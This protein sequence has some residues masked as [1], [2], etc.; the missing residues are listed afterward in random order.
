MN[1]RLIW[2]AC[3]IALTGCSLT[4][5][6]NK[7][8]ETH[9]RGEI[10]GLGNDTLYL[11]GTDGTYER[12]DT[13]LVK[14][15]KFDHTLH[16]DTIVSAVLVFNR[17]IYIP[18]FLTK[19]EDI[20]IQGSA[21]AL[22]FLTIEG[23]TPNEEYTTFQQTLKAQG[24]LSDNAPT[25]KAEA[26]IRNHPSSL[27]SIYL[28]NTYF[29][30]KPNPD[31]AKIESLI[32]G[33][34]G[35]LQDNPFI[36]QLKENVGKMKEIA[37]G[38]TAPYFRLPNAKKEMITRTEQFKDKYLLIHFWASWNEPSMKEQAKLRK[39]NRD[40]KKSKTFGMLGISFDLDK[41]AWE[42]AIKQDSLTWQQVCDFKGLNS[43]VAHQYG[44]VNLPSNVLIE[45]NGK[46]AAWNVSEEELKQLVKKQDA[47]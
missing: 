6:G 11:Y 16:V 28:L 7:V 15:G 17:G 42:K 2:L 30:Q 5:C 46:I 36:G 18:L 40:Y 3:I 4:G 34:S 9:L 8:Q 33:M 39:I 13:I 1:K 27:V 24:K 22:E 44:I 25:A 31:Y 19:K 20:M 38:K 14:E 23:S 47:N 21:D 29:V 37:V 43:E 45:P 32:E 10:T 12:I 41:A 26:F 35:T